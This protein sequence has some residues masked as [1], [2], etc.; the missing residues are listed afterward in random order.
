MSPL[1]QAIEV[2]IMRFIAFEMDDILFA[3]AE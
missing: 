2:E 1:A 3:K